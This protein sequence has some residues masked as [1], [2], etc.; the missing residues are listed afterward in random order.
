M[1]FKWLIKFSSSSNSHHHL[2]KKNFE[3]GN[4]CS[5]NMDIKVDSNVGV[6]VTK[7]GSS[8]PIFCWKIIDSINKLSHMNFF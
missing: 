5:F 4:C 1:S 3:I 7:Q 6:N 2:N 8:L